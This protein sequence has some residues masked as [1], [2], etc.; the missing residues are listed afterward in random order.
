MPLP[1]EGTPSPARGLPKFDE[2]I[3]GRSGA[4][5]VG[6]IASLGSSG[7]RIG[8]T[9]DLGGLMSSLTPWT[10]LLYQGSSSESGTR[11]C[12]RWTSASSAGVPPLGFTGFSGR[13][14]DTFALFG[15]TDNM[16]SGAAQGFQ[17]LELF[18]RLL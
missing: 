1:E 16:T 9:N 2:L 3:F 11:K 7:G 6:F 4:T 12:C 5:M 10:M 13:C 15:S 14:S 18:A 17:F 8:G